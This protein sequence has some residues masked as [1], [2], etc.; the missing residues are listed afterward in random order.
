M[1]D[2]RF[3]L[4]PHDL[5]TVMGQG[6]TAASPNRSVFVYEG[7]TGLHRMLNHPQILPRYY[8]AFIDLIDTFLNPQ[9]PNPL[10][11]VQ[12]PLTPFPMSP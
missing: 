5:D 12:A 8:A 11:P 2:P 6:N 4:V 3:V 9:T 7:V 1:E 10:L